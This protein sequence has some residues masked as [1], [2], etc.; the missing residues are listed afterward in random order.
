MTPASDALVFPIFAFVFGAVVGSFLNVCIYRLPR[1]LSVNQPR[2]SFCP[3]CE[4]PI[5]WH[6]NIP[7]LSW[8]ILRGRCAQCGT[9]IAFR[10]F[11]VEL[12]T[13]ILFWGIWVKTGGP[14][15]LLVLP[16]WIL[17][18]L[19]VVATFIDLE[20]YIIPDEITWGGVGA[21]LLLSIA[22]PQLMNSDSRLWAGLWSLTG[23][24]T[25][26][27]TLWAVVELGKL[28]F[29][30]KRVAFDSPK[31]FVWTLRGDDAELSLGDDRETWSELFARPSDRLLAE[32]E[33]LELGSERW[34]KV[35]LEFEYER[36]RLGERFWDLN[37]VTEI[38]ASVRSLTIPREAMGFGDV[39]FLASIGAFLGW[40]AVLFTV[41]AASF[42]GAIVGATAILVRHREWSARIPFGPYLAA[43]ALLWIFAGPDLVHWY[44]RFSFGPATP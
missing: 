36:L 11:G 7:L 14:Q 10:Y 26:Y 3:G 25:G 42:S 17:A 43:G 15:G 21:G 2:R 20:H 35:S 23:A 29:G 28:A 27:C 9:Q 24:V 12:L 40:K 33:W 30:K 38:R 32:A 41:A 22:L 6:H 37:Q 16:L 31:L 13:G 19:F 18:S 8:L 44:L 1:G 5:P 34:E 39:K 4:K